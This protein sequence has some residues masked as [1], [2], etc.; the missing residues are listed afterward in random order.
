M[1][2]W[3]N[4]EWVPPFLSSDS[5]VNIEPW[6]ENFVLAHYFSCHLSHPSPAFLSVT[7]EPV[8]TGSY[9]Q[10]WLMF[11]YWIVFRFFHRESFLGNLLSSYSCFHY[12][13]IL[14]MPNTRQNNRLLYFHG[15]TLKKVSMMLCSIS[16]LLKYVKLRHSSHD[17]NG[18]VRCISFVLPSFSTV[19]GR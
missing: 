19:P 14:F 7:Q 8:A 18:S 13:E 16:C 2:S 11:F 9:N 4:G 15:N 5:K 17:G 6:S 3:P 12:T 1:R 10:L